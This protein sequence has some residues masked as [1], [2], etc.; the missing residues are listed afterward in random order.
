MQHHLSKLLMASTLAAL[1][2]QALPRENGGG[3][4]FPVMPKPTPRPGSDPI[5]VVKDILNG[6]KDKID[7]LDDEDGQKVPDWLKTIRQRLNETHSDEEGKRQQEKLAQDAKKLLEDLS[8][9]VEDRS[10][11]YRNFSEAVKDPNHVLLQGLS[12]DDRPKQGKQKLG[13]D[14]QNKP[15]ADPSMTLDFTNDKKQFKQSLILAKL[16]LIG[17][18]DIPLKGN[19]GPLQKAERTAA[20]GTTYLE[21]STTRKFNG[22]LDNM[23]VTL[24]W[25]VSSDVSVLSDGN[26]LRPNGVK[27]S[28]TILNFPCQADAPLQLEQRVKVHGNS[29]NLQLHAEDNSVTINDHGSFTWDPVIMVDGVAQNVNA[30]LATSSDGDDDK[31]AVLFTFPC[32]QKI[33]WDPQVS[34]NEA[35]A[36]SYTEANQPTG[37]AGKVAASGWAAL[38]ASAFAL[39]MI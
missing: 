4:G 1:A 21:Y 14:L 9:K 20:D 23:E 29:T 30:T 27:Y 26:I 7:Q 15:D 10:F 5:D 19:W 3:N 18:Q 37:S 28:I 36:L 6:W 13:I 38:V 12:A 16:R 22:N 11:S 32:G 39:M 8:K 25:L 35:T 17:G 31:K 33:D 34:V 2:V 24:T